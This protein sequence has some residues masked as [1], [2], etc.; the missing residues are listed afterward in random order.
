MYKEKKVYVKKQDNVQESG[1]SLRYNKE[2]PPCKH[3][4]HLKL[5]KNVT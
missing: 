1:R 5:K 4:L 3:H 2:T